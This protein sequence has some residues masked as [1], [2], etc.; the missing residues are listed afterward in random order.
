M[1]WP[2]GVG[3]APCR[4]SSPEH[5]P[6]PGRDARG[7]RTESR[8]LDILPAAPAPPR[9]R[10]R[11]SRGML[12]PRGDCR[13]QPVTLARVAR[14]LPSCAGPSRR[15]DLFPGIGAQDC[16]RSHRDKKKQ[17][18]LRDHIAYHLASTP[19]RPLALLLR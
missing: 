12:N 15:L 14:R 3:I 10:V 18:L 2:D 13:S 6:P 11:F 4:R 8:L 16:A 5:P 7:D 1:P 17:N 19:E 9:A